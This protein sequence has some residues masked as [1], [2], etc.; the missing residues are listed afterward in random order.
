MKFLKDNKRILVSFSLV[1]TIGAF[2]LIIGFPTAKST[3]DRIH[4]QG[5]N[6]GEFPV[7]HPVIMDTSYT[8]EYIANIEAIQYIELK[9]RVDGFVESIHV[10]EGQRVRKGQ[11]L[12]RIGAQ[13]Y[14]A[15]LAEAKAAT[16]RAMAEA[17]TAEIEFRGVER[18]HG[19]GVVSET[20]LQLAQA[21]LDA[22][23]AIVEEARSNERSVQLD[24][25]YTRITAPFDGVIGRIA[26]R[27]GSFI[28]SGDAVTT[29]SDNSSVYAY[30]NVS[31]NDYLALTR[32]MEEQGPSDIALRLSDQRLYP[33]PGSIETMDNSFIRGSGT[34]A[35]R[36]SFPNPDGILK[37]GSSGML[38]IRRTIQ[39]AVIIPQRA[40]FEVQ[41][42]T[43]VFVL[44]ENNTAQRR[45]V[46]IAQRL[47]HLFILAENDLAPNDRIIYE[48]MHHLRDGEKVSPSLVSFFANNNDT[49]LADAGG[50]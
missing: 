14:E 40:T 10:D 41:S 45:E 22:L 38:S 5:G 6:V 49:A 27:T 42:K 7:V 9:A 21:K 2:A 30:F 48:G 20:E 15:K 33:Y 28:E 32:M 24:L 29:I 13:E 23:N 1:L 18:L 35:F 47:Q 50:R 26:K 3:A 8:I 44:D 31:E 4:G 43:Y 16:R 11:L 37:N 17:R 19:N 36:A 39:D 12:F 46:R 34:I 25:S